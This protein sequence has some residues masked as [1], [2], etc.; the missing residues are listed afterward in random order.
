M[1][2]CLSLSIYI[3]IYLSKHTFNSSL[4]IVILYTHSIL[5]LPFISHPIHSPFPPLTH[6]Y[7]FALPPTTFFSFSLLSWPPNL[8]SP[9]SQKLHFTLPLFLPLLYLHSFYALPSPLTLTSLSSHP[10]F[11]LLS[12]TLSLSLPG[13][14]FPLIPSSIPNYTQSYLFW[15][16][17]P[18]F[19]L[20]LFTLPTPIRSHS[21]NK[22]SHLSHSF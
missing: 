5:Y 21:V 6:S 12:S 18:S 22:L 11:T 10:H 16:Y 7:L 17:L 13:R 15:V 1:L 2:F 14:C 19:P 9:P 4:P 20:S 8:F 3:F